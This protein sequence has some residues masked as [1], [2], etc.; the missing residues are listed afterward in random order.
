M[1]FFYTYV[2]LCSDGDWYIGSTEDIKHRLVEH[3]QGKCETNKYRL[4]VELIYFEACRSLKAA[5]EREKQ[6]KTGFG[7]AYL[8]RRLAK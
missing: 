3:K 2:L 1:S 5:R 4:P 8:N 7:R 6:L